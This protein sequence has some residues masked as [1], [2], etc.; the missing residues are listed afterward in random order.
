MQEIAASTGRQWI[1]LV[2]AIINTTVAILCIAHVMTCAWVGIVLYTDREDNWLTLSAMANAEPGSDPSLDP[3][4][5]YLH[6][7]RFI[8]NAPSPPLLAK[9]SVVER[10]FDILTNIFTFVVIGGT[11]SKLVGTVSELRSMNAA[12]SRQRIDLRLYLQSQDASF[13]LISRVL[14]FADYKL[15]KM[16]PATFDPTLISHTLQ[17]EISVNQRAR[18]IKIVPIFDL[19][20]QLWPEV[21]SSICVVLRKVVCE[22]HEEVFTAGDLS[23]LLYV[24]V[25]GEFR[26]VEG[27]EG[28]GEVTELSGWGP[29]PCRPCSW[30]CSWACMCLHHSS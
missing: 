26:H 2:V 27:F 20:W 17:T 21:F 22:H 10:V 23:T 29:R 3:V 13:E 7:F 24:T 25:T 6:A 9:D 16:V 4:L 14:K 8:L 18:F 1:M 28:Q 12:K 5:K 19:T 15:D 11:V 30:A